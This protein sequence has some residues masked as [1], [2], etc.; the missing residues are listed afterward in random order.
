MVAKKAKESSTRAKDSLKT[1]IAGLKVDKCNSTGDV[2][3]Y[4]LLVTNSLSSMSACIKVVD[5]I[6]QL[7][8]L[9]KKNVDLTGKRLAEQIRHETRMFEMNESMY[10]LKGSLDKKDSELNSSI[11]TLHSRKEAFFRYE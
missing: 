9:D 11:A 2:Y 3:V 8:E 5:H 10:V 1:R 4:D 7:S 6:D